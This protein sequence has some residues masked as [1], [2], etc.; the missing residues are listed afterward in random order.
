MYVTEGRSDLCDELLACLG[1]GDAPR[2]PIEKPDAQR[3]LQLSDRIAERGRGH[4]KL[5]GG[6]SVLPMSGDHE[7]RFQL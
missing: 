3:P 5:D 2:G 7:N 1:Q 6:R 4:A